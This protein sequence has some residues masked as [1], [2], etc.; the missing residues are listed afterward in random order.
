MIISMKPIEI[1]E[2]TITGKRAT[3]IEMAGQCSHKH[4]QMAEDGEI[5]TCNDC[6]RQVT[7]WW[8]LMRMVDQQARWHNEMERRGRALAE[9]EKK[10]L[11]LKA[12]QAI[13]H[14]WRKR[15][16]VPVCP[17]CRKPILPGDGFGNICV[18]KM[19]VIAERQSS[20]LG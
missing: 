18:S 1:G 6:K 3:L 16:L 5:I 10:G 13:E 19:H 9:S 11:T 14:C 8:V 4:L 12:A 2:Y 20:E 7:A 17:H 15:K